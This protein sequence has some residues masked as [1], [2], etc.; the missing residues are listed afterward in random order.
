MIEKPDLFSQSKILMKKINEVIFLK[1]H[2]QI[3][4]K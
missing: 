2:I 4:K 1:D 3:E